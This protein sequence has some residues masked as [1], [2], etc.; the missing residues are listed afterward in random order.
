[1]KQLTKELGEDKIY[2]EMTR[3]AKQTLAFKH[4][5]AEGN[6]KIA[7]YI[8]LRNKKTGKNLYCY[9]PTINSIIATWSHLMEARRQ[10]TAEGLNAT[11]YKV[12]IK[13]YW[14][15]KI[16]GFVKRYRNKLRVFVQLVDD[17]K[18]DGNIT[19]SPYYIQISEADETIKLRKFAEE[20]KTAYEES[21]ASHL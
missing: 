7:E 1:M 20:I 15:A 6:P 12:V 19:L 8:E 4:F 18:N 16:M 14:K 17:K 2:L 3:R 11:L 9:L 5:I 13:V 21:R 10:Q